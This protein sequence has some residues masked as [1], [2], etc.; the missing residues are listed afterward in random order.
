VVKPPS[1]FLGGLTGFVRLLEEFVFLK[2]S[3]WFFFEETG[4][5]FEGNAESP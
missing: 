5:F 4:E 1:I 3:G 2:R